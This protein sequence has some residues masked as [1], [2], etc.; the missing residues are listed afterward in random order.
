MR[1]WILAFVVVVGFVGSVYI[2]LGMYAVGLTVLGL[3]VVMYLCVR[4]LS[5]LA[6]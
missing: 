6:R 3:N 2:A 1:D 4:A 5:W